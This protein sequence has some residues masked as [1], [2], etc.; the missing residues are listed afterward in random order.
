MPYHKTALMLGKKNNI[1]PKQNTSAFLCGYVLS[2]C[3]NVSF[4]YD[5]GKR[6][7][8]KVAMSSTEEMMTLLDHKGFEVTDE[9]KQSCQTF[10]LRLYGKHDGT[11]NE[12][13]AHIYSITSR[14]STASSSYRRCILSA[15]SS[16]FISTFYI[17]IKLV[18][19]LWDCLTQHCSV[20]Q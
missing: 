11:L 8:F 9:V 13:R 10:F 19:L 20:E 15:C 17:Q 16:S 3:D 2:G 7:A 6:K 1:T 4:P 14:R 12:V 5:K 18:A